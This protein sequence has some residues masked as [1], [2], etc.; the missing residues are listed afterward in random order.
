MVRFGSYSEL[1]HF[2]LTR[3][4]C[5]YQYFTANYNQQLSLYGGPGRLGPAVP[6]PLTAGSATST[7]SVST[8]PSHSDTNNQVSGVDEL[9]TVKTDGQYIYTVSNNTVDIVDAYPVSGAQLV[10]KISLANQTIDGIFVEG[11]QL[12]VISEAPR[13][14]VN[15]YIGCGGISR[16]MPLLYQMGC[17][18]GSQIQNSSISVYDLT[19]RS[20][21]KPQTTVTVNGTFI[22]ARLIGTYVYLVSSFPAEINQTLPMTVVNGKVIETE[23]TQ[24]YH[25][26][27]SDQAFS[28]T[29]ITALNMNQENPTPNVQTFLLGTSSTIYVSL[30]NI[31]LTQPTWDQNGETVIHRISVNNSSITYEATGSVPGHVLNQFSMDEYNDYFRV[32]T[33]G[34]GYSGSQTSLYVLSESM[35]IVG[36]LERISPGEVFYA[37]RFM[38]DRAYLVTFKRLDPLFV[39]NLQNPNSPSLMGQLNVTGASDYLQ[40]Y[41]STHLIGIGKSAQDVGWENA[42]LFLGLKISLFDVTNPN[43]P[44]DMSDFTV[45]DRG[46]DSPALTDQKALLFDQSLNLLVIP[47]NVVGQIPSSMVPAGYSEKI[48]QGAFVFQVNLQNGIVFRGSITHLPND[49]STIYTSSDFFITRSL[50]IG[51]VLYTISNAMIKM[52]SLAD[53]SP[54]GAVNLE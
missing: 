45:G 44:T 31:F 36:R 43:N 46:T 51:G 17:Y 6:G 14:P 48:C 27:V 50:Y 52:N 7:S 23:A 25:S 5:S 32:A 18:C 42:A 11:N 1:E 53:L 15:S 26:D 37:A 8:V 9:D 40:P 33:S 12:S 21:P 38:G 24:I 30:T 35:N 34:Y 20:S 3:S 41:D 10:S 2:L 54:L 49:A 13:N 4:S 19:D 39:V 47:I 28:Y 16:P 29:T 22:G